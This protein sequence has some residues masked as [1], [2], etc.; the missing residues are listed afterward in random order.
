M[1]R[2][3]DR[4]SD[5]ARMAGRLRSS[6]DPRPL[7]AERRRPAPLAPYLQYVHFAR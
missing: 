4:A 5:P 7:H 2:A 3:L 1:T 6:G